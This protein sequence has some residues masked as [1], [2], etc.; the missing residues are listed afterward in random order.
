MYK[1]A[2]IAG[3]LTGGPES[4]GF[5]G[6]PAEPGIPGDPGGPCEETRKKQINKKS[7]SIFKKMF[8][9]DYFLN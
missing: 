1:A 4:P 5:P 3:T 7:K 2:V 6:F 8:L 9:K